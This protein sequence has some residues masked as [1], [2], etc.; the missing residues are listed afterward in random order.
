MIHTESS[1]SLEFPDDNWF[2]FQDCIHYKR[3]NHIREVDFCWYN[4]E[5]NRL[6]LIELKDWGDESLDEENDPKYSQEDIKN[7]KKGISKYRVRNLFEKSVDSLSMFS[8]ILM[9]RPLGN[10]INGCI[11]FSIN[12]D[13]E[14][15]LLS[16]INWTSPDST[17]ISVINSAYRSNLNSYAKL[18]GAKEYQVITKKMAAELFDW[19]LED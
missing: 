10:R 5:A 8:S 4:E 14:I 12:L 13:T 18:F 1:I 11:P 9:D 17:Y 16:I 7:K 6:F 15:I 2:R 3:L 19:V